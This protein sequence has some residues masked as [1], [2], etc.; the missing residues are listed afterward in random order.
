MRELQQ[1]PRRVREAIQQQQH[2]SE[3]LL[4]WAQLIIVF[5]FRVLYALSPR[6]PTISSSI[7]PV[8]FALAAYFGFTLLRI[9]L[10]YRRKLPRWFVYLSIVIDM[11]LLMGLIWTF[12]LQYRQPPSFYLKSPTLLYVFIFIALRALYFEYRFVAFAGAV[13]ALGWSFLVLYAV[14][15]NPGDTMI[16]RD[17]VQYITSNSVLLGAEF[18]KIFAILMVTAV[19]NCRDQTLSSAAI[20]L[21]HRGDYSRGTQALRTGCGRSPGRRIRPLE[22]RRRRGTRGDDTVQRY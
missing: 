9:V 21:G 17:Y 18:D 10:A 5:A 6:T 12:R 14:E 3:I 19:L 8:P 20:T 22:R 1:L 4:C 15:V 16:T 7:E 13:A 2:S 11:T